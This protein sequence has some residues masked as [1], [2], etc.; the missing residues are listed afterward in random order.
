MSANE[1]QLRN[2]I[3][4]QA[5]DWFVANRAGL[6]ARESREFDAWLKTSPVH[7]EEYLALMSMTRDLRAASGRLQASVGSLDEL[8]SR[9]RREDESSVR[10]LWERMIAVIGSPQPRRWQ[11]A[12]AALA[13]IA[14][15]AIALT[16]WSLKPL[17]QAHPEA[18]VTTLHFATGH[19]E[20]LTQ[21]LADN[22]VLHLN[23]DSAATVRFSATE[24]RVTLETGEADFEVVHQALRPFRVLAG[25]AEVVDVG[26]R[27]DVRLKDEATTVTVVEGRVD[28]GLSAVARGAAGTAAAPKARV[29]QLTA[30]QQIN[31]SA[32]D[33]PAAAV[34]VDAQRATAWLHRQ[35]TFEHEP[36]A[37]V[38]S[39]FN[40]YSPKPIDIASPELRDLEISGVFSTDDPEA[41]I[42]FLRSLDGVRVEVTATQVRVSR[43]GS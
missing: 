25:S 6:S 17:Q 2:L 18:A 20:L 28:V 19:G 29:V 33:W 15:V 37:R 21:Q 4:Q 7:V 12:M 5:A 43:H 30:N 22:S 42:A 27:F 32:A 38:A 34:P 36:L 1:A 11:H 8:I 26:T 14:V 3:G 16:L 24:R 35:I 13:A 23:T 31:V 9:A 39:E 41:F 10:P 40:R